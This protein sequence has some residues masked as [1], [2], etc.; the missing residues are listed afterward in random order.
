MS[1]G[2]GRRLGP[3]GS[4]GRGPRRGG[5]GGPGRPRRVDLGLPDDA[6]LEGEIDGQVGTVRRRAPSS[7]RWTSAS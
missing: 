3:G 4:R 1:G 2:G 5:A 6:E 7:R